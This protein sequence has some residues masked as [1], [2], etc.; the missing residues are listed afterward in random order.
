MF[1][2]LNNFL[3]AHFAVLDFFPMTFNF[4]FTSRDFMQEIYSLPLTTLKN[5]I[6][7]PMTYDVCNFCRIDEKLLKVKKYG[8]ILLQQF[9]VTR[10]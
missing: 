10:I 4:H 2:N 1:N 3:A 9:F 5:Y 6:R 7:K 8:L